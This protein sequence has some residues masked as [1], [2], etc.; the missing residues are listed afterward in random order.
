MVQSAV[1]PKQPGTDAREDAERPRGR[2]RPSAEVPGHNS[3]LATKILV[4]RKSSN[5]AAEN[6][7]RLAGSTVRRSRLLHVWR[8]LPEAHANM[9][10][11]CLDAQAPVYPQGPRHERSKGSGSRAG[12]AC[13]RRQ[14]LPRYVTRTSDR[15][16]RRDVSLLY[17]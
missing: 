7:R 3:I 6:E 17:K 9:D 11:H 5:G 2:G 13:T 8:P 16:D 10:K 15:A 4:H 14:L 1:Y 12:I